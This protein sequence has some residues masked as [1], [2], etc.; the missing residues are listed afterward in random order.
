MA[1]AKDRF[2]IGLVQ[3][4][5]GKDIPENLAQAEALIRDA[6]GRGARYI[7]TPEN[8]NIMESSAPL[9]LEK[10]ATEGETGAVGRFARLSREL[11]IW[12][13]IGSL[14]VKVGEGHAANRAFLFAPD[15]EAVLCYD[16]IHMFDVDLPS[17]E[18]YRE[19]ATFVPGTC[20][21]VAE[22]PWGGLGVATC[23]DIRF[24]EQYKALARAGAKFLTAPSAFTKVTGEAH[25][26]ILLRARA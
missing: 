7:Q 6:A 2:R 22:L 10:I 5:S 12:L 18:T 8:T 24:P 20:A 16:K 4:R 15:G 17:G 11:R 21:F 13:H 25:W 19:S 14:A 23:Y 9:L 3:L 1:Q 26:H